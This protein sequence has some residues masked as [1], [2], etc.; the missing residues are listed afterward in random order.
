MATTLPHDEIGLIDYRWNGTTAVRD[1][2]VYTVT[3]T[4]SYTIT[5]HEHNIRLPAN[6]TE[7]WCKKY[8]AFAADI[9]DD[10]GGTSFDTFIRKSAKWIGPTTLEFQITHEEKWNYG[11]SMTEQGIIDWLDE[12]S[13]EDGI[14]EGDDDFWIIHADDATE[15]VGKKVVFRKKTEKNA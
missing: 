11:E 4:F 12:D 14:Y 10:I 15:V 5:D 7:L 9:A 1:G 3:V 2:D 6:F 8:E 13:L